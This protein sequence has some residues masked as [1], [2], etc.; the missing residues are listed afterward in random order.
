[1][2]ILLEQEIDLGNG[3]SLPNLY[4]KYKELRLIGKTK[5]EL[6]IEMYASKEASY[7]GLKP[8]NTEKLNFET[9]GL[10][11]TVNIWAFIHALMKNKYPDAVDIIEDPTTIAPEIEQLIQVGNDIIVTGSCEANSVIKVFA[12]GYTVANIETTSN[13]FSYNIK[14]FILNHRYSLRRLAFNAKVKNKKKSLTVRQEVVGYTDLECEAH[15]EALSGI[16]FDKE[17]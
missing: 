1:M 4:I 12:Y 15:E 6:T 13:T 16:S 9:I 5:I 3:L 17:P 14:D 11:Y 2:A 10:D 7:N 8:F